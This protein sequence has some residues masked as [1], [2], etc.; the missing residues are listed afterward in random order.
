M[1]PY[2]VGIDVGGTKLAYGLFDQK[3]QLLSR[4]EKPSQPQ[5]SAEEIV[6]QLLTHVQELLADAGCGRQELAGVG[7][8]FPSYVNAET[9]YIIYSTNM[10]SLNG[11]DMRD[12]MQKRF[13]VPVQIDNDANA[14]AI[15][16]HR[17]GAGRG[18]RHMLYITIS[19]GIGGGIII[20][21][22]L[23]RGSHG[24]A[25]EIGHVL[26]SENE[27]V[28]CGCGNRGCVESLS[29]GP[30]MASYAAWRMA[31]GQKSLL[32]EL[33]GGG[34][35]TGQHIGQALRQGDALALE[36]VEH[37]AE[38]LARLFSSLYQML[39][40]DYVVYGGGAVKIGPELMDRAITRF[41]E[42]T[43]YA[44]AYPVS[45]V[46]AEL[47]DNAGIIGAALLMEDLQR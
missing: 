10:P 20:D 46:P 42:L 34:N 4:L 26:V 2:Y 15:A 40:I 11:L 14:A 31:Q 22:H 45:Y 29:S 18:H 37:G 30:S 13:A 6:D 39:N 32:S 41:D 25:G 9:G 21:N 38:Y 24:M 43:Q 33:A 16:E 7:A 17:R 12:M 35:I 3:N 1:G 8:C 27:G 19:T 23:F 47:G 5:L 44:H 36:T 28:Q